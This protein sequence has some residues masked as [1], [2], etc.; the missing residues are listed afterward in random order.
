MNN[1][2]GCDMPVS[3]GRT[4][5]GENVTCVTI[6]IPNCSVKN[7]VV[8][9]FEGLLTMERG[10]SVFDKSICT[11]ALA[12]SD[13]VLLNTSRVI[14]APTQ[15]LLK[16]VIFAFYRLGLS[17]YRK[18]K[19]IFVLR[20]MASNDL[21]EF[22]NITKEIENAMLSYFQTSS[23]R[24]QLSQI[25]DQLNY[26]ALASALHRQ[27]IAWRDTFYSLREHIIQSIKH[28]SEKMPED[29][30][31]WIAWINACDSIWTCVRTNLNLM[32]AG[33]L[34]EMHFKEQMDKYLN[35]TLYSSETIIKL[36]QKIVEESER[37][38]G[39]CTLTTDFD[40]L[41]RKM[42]AKIDAEFKLCEVE[43]VKFF[44]DRV[45]TVQTT[46]LSAFENYKNEV[47]PREVK[48]NKSD[49]IRLW[50][51]KLDETKQNTC[52]ER[53]LMRLLKKIEEEARQDRYRMDEEHKIIFQQIWSEEEKNLSSYTAKLYRG[54]KIVEQIQESYSIIIANNHRTQPNDLSQLID[55]IKPVLM[56]IEM[57]NS[58][59][60]PEPGF[61]ER[62]RN[63]F[64]R[65]RR[66]NTEK[67]YFMNIRREVMTTINSVPR[68]DTS[69]FPKLHETI[70]S[71]VHKL[72]MEINRLHDDMIYDIQRS[73]SVEFY[74]AAHRSLYQKLCQYY[75]NEARIERARIQSLFTENR[76]KLWNI[77]L[78][79]VRKI[80]NDVNTAKELVKCLQNAL[81][82]YSTNESNLQIR[83]EDVD[84]ILRAYYEDIISPE[85]LDKLCYE[86]TFLR[87]DED[88][89]FCFIIDRR[90]YLEKT[91]NEYY[92]RYTNVLLH[93]KIEEALKS[94]YTA[95]STESKSRFDLIKTEVENWL[96]EKQNEKEVRVYD[97]LVYLGTKHELK[98]I[99]IPSTTMLV[100][101]LVIENVKIV[102]D[103]LSTYGNIGEEQE[104]VKKKIIE[105]IRDCKDEIKNVSFGCSDLCPYCNTKCSK[106]AG[107]PDNHECYAHLISGFGNCFTVG[108][109]KL[110]TG[111]CTGSSWDRK[112]KEFGKAD[113]S[114]RYTFAQHLQKFHPE[115]TILQSGAKF[116]PKEQR[117]M[118][119]K[120]NKK[121]AKHFGREEGI[122]DE[123]PDDTN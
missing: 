49:V 15:E 37:E 5:R 80:Y 25:L 71:C 102:Q 28:F 65:A 110:Y 27:D 90:N 103:N 31:N 117:E 57:K 101:G 29:H 38:L 83:S 55:N 68:S 14:D 82:N 72:N 44:T 76:E 30:R 77:Y 21:S 32:D 98:P 39:A 4:T 20:D 92:E 22:G 73:L 61:F 116:P 86:K 69:G 84:V 10:G 56:G 59:I 97:L 70:R 60:E 79:K 58:L 43:V 26:K 46:L 66:V 42:L 16:Y 121:L 33:T 95:N 8:Q 36:R 105:C 122:D 118:F 104:R 112:W 107:H 24:V 3:A 7:I 48:Q 78:Q 52:I 99:L 67:D 1:L 54:D 23:N 41:N 63:I 114:E 12:T 34:S 120:L 93:K 50:K 94:N 88:E 74:K 119:R 62:L 11:Y 51:N 53:C 6:N 87:Q 100:A 85:A 115:W 45:G 47:I 111:Y 64:T 96:K 81:F 108:T 17:K 123:W 113:S 40:E 2:F 75:L 106:K 91:W 109:N 13:L 18:P 35:E 89:T 19:V 9:D